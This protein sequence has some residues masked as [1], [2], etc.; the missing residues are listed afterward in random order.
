MRGITAVSVLAGHAFFF[1]WFSGRLRI[2]SI[3]ASTAPACRSLP[4]AAARRAVGPGDALPRIVSHL[5]AV[6]AGSS[7]AWIPTA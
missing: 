3:T 2:S 5:A 7:A 1:H 4:L 6:A